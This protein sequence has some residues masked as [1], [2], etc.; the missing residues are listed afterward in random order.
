MV[1]TAMMAIPQ[2]ALRKLDFLV[3]EYSG[4]Q[5]LF[6]PD[7][8]ARSYEVSCCI[9]REACERFVKVEFFADV[10]E[11]GVESHTGLLTFNAAKN[12]YQMWLFSSHA[13]EPMVMTGDF[14][15]H[16]LVMV[17][18]P[19]LMPWGLQRIRGVITPFVDGS[20]EFV[21]ELWAPDGYTKFRHTLFRRQAV[22]L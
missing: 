9:S 18:E 1:N 15:E 7:G 21:T 6:P 8:K 12:L 16:Q 17:S 11:F 22:N 14:R 5:M 13:E 4:T 19:W 20:F 10:P 2:T 3:G